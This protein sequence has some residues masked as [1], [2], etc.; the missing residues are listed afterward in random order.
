M[1]TIVTE[2]AVIRVTKQD[3][4]SK[5]WLL[6]CVCRTCSGSQRRHFIS[7]ELKDIEQLKTALQHRTRL[8]LPDYAFGS[9]TSSASFRPVYILA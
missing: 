6:K 7:A 4:S 1:Q 8:H 9:S 5:K 3:W 2:L